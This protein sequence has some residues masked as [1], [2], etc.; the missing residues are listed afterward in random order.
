VVLD[1]VPARVGAP[2]FQRTADDIAARSIVLVRDSMGVV[3]RMR[4]SPQRVALVTYGDDRSPAVGQTLVAE[5]RARGH[6]VTLTRLW[7]NSGEASHDSARAALAASTTSIF[8]IAARPLPWDASRLTLPPSIA[9][10]VDSTATTRPTILV[11]LGSPYT[12]RSTP[13]VG[14]YLVGWLANP[15]MERAVAGALAGAEITGRLPVR[16]PPFDTVGGGL[17]LPAS[18]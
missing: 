16:I 15:T 2:E 9:R 8:A 18:R 1:S 3:A 6:S 17:Q 10:L 11:S 7:P 13:A 5:L 12:V 14:S 4:A